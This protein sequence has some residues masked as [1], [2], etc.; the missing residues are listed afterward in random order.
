MIVVIS[1][2]VRPTPR[3]QPRHLPGWAGAFHD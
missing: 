3:V 2:Q 1:D